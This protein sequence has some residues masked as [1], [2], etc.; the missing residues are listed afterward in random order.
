MQYNRVK[1]RSNNRP[2]L[3]LISSKMLGLVEI[4]TANTKAFESL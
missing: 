3:N 4:H 2:F 1:E